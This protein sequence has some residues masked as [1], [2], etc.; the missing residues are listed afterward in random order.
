MQI[1]KGNSLGRRQFLRSTAAGIIG[2][3]GGAAAT[4]TVT[5]GDGYDLISV[6]AHG[7]SWSYEIGAFK[8][9]PHTILKK[10]AGADD[11]DII[12]DQ[13]TYI[14]AG[15]NPGRYDSYYIHPDANISRVVA[16]F[17]N[18]NSLFRLRTN[19]FNGD[20][21]FKVEA[22]GDNEYSY[23]VETASRITPQPFSVEDNDYMFNDDHGVGGHVNPLGSDVYFSN[24]DFKTVKIINPNYDV[25]TIQRER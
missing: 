16:S 10:G 13:T 20:N 3:A 4:G 6:E 21:A 8:T 18:K 17:D 5:A 12:N 24:R 9:V 7:E 14:T 1:M 15:I 11:G 22:W 25:L 23:E 19:K 2:I